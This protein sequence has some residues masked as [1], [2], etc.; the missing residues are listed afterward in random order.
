MANVSRP[1]IGLL[2]GTVAFFALWITALKPSRPGAARRRAASAQYQSAI[3][4]GPPRRPAVLDCPGEPVLAGART[5]ARPHDAR[6]LE[7][8]DV[9]RTRPPPRAPPRPP[10]RRPRT[11]GRRRRAEPT[12]RRRRR[13]SLAPARRPPRSSS[14]TRSP[15]PWS[16][17][18]VIALLFYNPALDRRPGRPAGAG[19]G[20]DHRG[21]VLRLAVPI[22]EVAQLPDRQPDPDQPVADAR[23]DRPQPRRR[24]RS[25]GSPT[26]SRSPSA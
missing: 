9:E 10:R 19:R 11:A 1:L 6:G 3:S 18:R 5:P 17:S 16:T 2:I 21:S 7:H 13:R 12:R 20:A 22:D 26:G 24:R 25:S 8:G 4:A 23:A 14:S 15:G